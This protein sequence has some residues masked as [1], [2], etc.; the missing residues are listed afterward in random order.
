MRRLDLG[1]YIDNEATPHSYVCLVLNQDIDFKYF[2]LIY[3]RATLRI[4][5]DGGYNRLRD[6][7]SSN[8]IWMT[9]PDYIIGDLDSLNGTVCSC[10]KCVKILDQNR[11]DVQK[12]LDYSIEHLD[13]HVFVV[14]GALGGRFDHE[15]QALSI[16]HQYRNYQLIYCNEQSM[17][18]LLV[19]GQYEVAY[20]SVLGHHCGFGPLKG[21]AHVRTSGLRWDVDGKMELGSFISS[22]NHI[23][24]EITLETDN[25]IIFTIEIK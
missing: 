24:S 22:S 4:C 15:L 1:Q 11:N 23:S 8:R 3:E 10:I 21:V 25:D 6:W 16:L 14:I 9:E 17:I 7:Y 5:A 2:R 19:P 13:C 12:C 18:C 20:T